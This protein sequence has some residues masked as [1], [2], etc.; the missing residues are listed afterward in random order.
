MI[1]NESPLVAITN[2]TRRKAAPGGQPAGKE[3]VD[4]YLAA[5]PPAQRATLGTLRATIRAAAPHA[6]E[7]MAYGMPAFYDPGPL[8]AYAAFKDHCSF[9]P[10]SLETMARF[11]HEL[12]PYEG[13]K[14]SVHFTLERP[15]PAALVKRLVRE[16]IRENE[17]RRMARERK[18]RR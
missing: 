11:K 7:K 6:V 8:V 13:T 18:K 14:G 10:M 9:F 15:L 5:L 12:A 16:R 3:A 4:R 2:E 17:E 1:N